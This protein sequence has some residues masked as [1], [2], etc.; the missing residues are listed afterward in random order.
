VHRI[1]LGNTE[2]E[3]K[4]S[5]YLFDGER[6]TLVDT[7]VAVPEIS[8]QLEAGLADHGVAVANLDAIVLTHWHVDHAGLAG[9]LQAESGAT[10]Y[11]HPLDAPLVERDP[12]A[13]AANEQL[14]DRKF[15]EWGMPEGPREQLL[16]FFDATSDTQGDGA[17]VDPLED[18]EAF[19]AGDETLRAVHTPGHTDGHLAFVREDGPEPD[20]VLTGDALLPKY[21]PNVGGA[22]PRVDGPLG[23]YLDTLSWLVDM[24]FERAYP[25]HRD[26]IDD[27]TARA[28]EIIGHHRERA[29]R[30]LDY[31]LE[32]GPA[33]AW[34]VSAHLFGGLEGI[35]I[36]HGP[37][38]AYA[39]L[40]HMTRHGVL[41]VEDGQYRVVDDDP[42]LT[43][44]FA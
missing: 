43:G 41:D 42:D 6:T 21:T 4:N 10:V 37:G 23:K 13:E 8:D 3:G 29:E 16:S 11:A 34:T 22:D 35:H 20:T 30:V 44:L 25:G 15:A 1:K 39:H 36:M 17:V 28:H 2:F 5:A 14:R 31:L 24:G 38:E 7:G 19:R 26:P 32:E 27:P 18:G 9:A 12:D 33:D 40:E